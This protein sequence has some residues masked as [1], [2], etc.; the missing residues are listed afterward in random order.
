MKIKDFGVEMWM[1]AYENDCKYNLAETCVESLTVNELLEMNGKKEEII[2]EIL[3]M[4][5]T[6]GAIEGSDSLR[7][8]VSKLFKSNIGIN[9]IT[10]THGGI[11]A[12]A[13][14]ILTLV[15]PKD[16][17]ISVLPTYQQHYSIPESIGADVKI[18][19]LR[20]ENNFLPDLNE[21]RS[22]VNDKTKLIC[23]NNP[24]NPTG[25]VMDEA[26]LKE[27]VEIA[28]SCN[29]YLLCDE[30]Y[31]GLIHEGDSFGY[32]VV[33]LY[34]KGISSGSVSKT[35]S[36]AGLR[37]GWLVGP[38]EFIE[39]VNRQRDYHVISVGKI[40]DKLATIALENKEKILERNLRIVRENAILLEQW[41]NSE[42][43]LSYVKPKGGT[44][45]F[46]KYD[47]NISSEEF[48]IRLQEIKGVMMLPGSALDME[49]FIRIGYCNNP[50][51]LKKGL[52]LTSE[53][54]RGLESSQ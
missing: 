7:T 26:Y 10:I 9:N 35:F 21:L 37:T 20:P 51:I 4:Q 6:Y 28:K 3:N 15:E 45:A 24:N 18:L 8:E 27:I 34:E 30:V 36:L 47:Y 43:K 44:T 50:E 19:K 16:R 32:S 11:S 22:Y 54:L 48:C 17:V 39:K 38:E 14:A 53:F 25:S 31:R 23:I 5:L 49:G 40:N 2:K 29:A 42:P 1:N 52:E 33:D 13:L 12:N 41:I 46:F